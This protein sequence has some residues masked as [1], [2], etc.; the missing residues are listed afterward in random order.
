MSALVGVAL[1]V[2]IVA[3]LPIVQ[4]KFL[5]TRAGRR[6]YGVLARNPA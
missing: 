2:E 1:I 4:I 5:L 6:A 3:L